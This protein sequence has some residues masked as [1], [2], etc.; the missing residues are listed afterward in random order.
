MYGAVCMRCYGIFLNKLKSV[1]YDWK[2]VSKKCLA[3]KQL[4]LHRRINYE[5]IL[6]EQLRKSKRNTLFE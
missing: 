4:G 5:E 1:H 6:C 2:L 3:I